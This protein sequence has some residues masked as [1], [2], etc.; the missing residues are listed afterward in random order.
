MLRPVPALCHGA[1][2]ECSLSKQAGEGGGDLAAMRS[3]LE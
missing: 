2:P 1:L 3:R